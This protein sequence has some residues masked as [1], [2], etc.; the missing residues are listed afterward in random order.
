MTY[1]PEYVN[2][3]TAPV[4]NIFQAMTKINTNLEDISGEFS[5]IAEDI[6]GMDG[7]IEN[8]EGEYNQYTIFTETFDQITTSPLTIG[9]QPANS[10]IERIIVEITTAATAGSPTLSIGI[11]ADTDAYMETTDIDLSVLGKY[12]MTCNYSV[13]ADTDIL[14]TIVADSQTFAG[15]IQVYVITNYNS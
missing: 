1:T 4:D 7:R 3:D 12:E 13:I 15:T 9:E 2:H 11:A 14:A 6:S 5:D 8:L 10:I